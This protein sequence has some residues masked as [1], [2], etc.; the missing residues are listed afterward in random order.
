MH[1]K[2]A[3]NKNSKSAFDL[4]KNVKNL[5]KILN[6]NVIELKTKYSIVNKKK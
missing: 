4:I 6:K 5:K 3:K 2:F 1:D